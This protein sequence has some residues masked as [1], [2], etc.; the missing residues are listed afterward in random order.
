MFRIDTGTITPE[1]SLMDEGGSYTRS[2][3]GAERVAREFQAAGAPLAIVYPSGVLGPDGPGVSVNHEALVV[4]IRTPP[5]TS[6]GTGVVDVRDVALGIEHALGQPGR[7]M[8]GGT[9]LTWSQMHDTLTRVTGVRRRSV[10]MPGRLLR[11]AGRGGD[12]VKRVRPFDFPLTLEAMTS[13]ESRRALRQSRNSD[14]LGVQ[15][16][17]VEETLRDSIRWLAL[18]R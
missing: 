11:L 4:W 15:W 3:I 18:D 17:P 6:S 1:T 7:W 8:F 16:R 10:P 5:R 2:K 13:R 14:V 12:L 9:F